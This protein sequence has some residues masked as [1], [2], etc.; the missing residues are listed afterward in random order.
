MV[1]NRKALRWRSNLIFTSTNDSQCILEVWLYL[2][3]TVHYRFLVVY[4]KPSLHNIVC[5]SYIVCVFLVESVGLWCCVDWVHCVVIFHSI[6]ALLFTQWPL[7]FYV[8]VN[9]PSQ[10]MYKYACGMCT[11]I[12]L[13]TYFALAR[14]HACTCTCCMYLYLYCTCVRNIILL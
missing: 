5:F 14:V 10:L 2:P 6:E 12:L 3:V 4:A 11:I 8:Q 13:Y 9:L 1:P 7:P